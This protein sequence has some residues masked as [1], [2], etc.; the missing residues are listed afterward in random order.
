[1]GEPRHRVAAPRTERGDGRESRSR[2]APGDRD[3]R[4]A[5]PVTGASA[6]ANSAPPPPARSSEN[7]RRPIT[8]SANSGSPQRLPARTVRMLPGVRRAGTVVGTESRP[9]AP[10]P[11]PDA[12]AGRD[13]SGPSTGGPAPRPAEMWSPPHHRGEVG[14]AHG[15]VVL[16]PVRTARLRDG[17]PS[18]GGRRRRGTHV[19]R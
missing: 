18:V 19:V 17:P 14:A 12:P 5:L 6:T 4:S 15:L 8:S 1:M 3:A 16:L 11:A 9:P 13:R 10:A 2:T 7:L